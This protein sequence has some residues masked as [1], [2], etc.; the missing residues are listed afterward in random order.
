MEAAI[1]DAFPG[2]IVRRVEIDDDP[3]LMG[4]FGRDVPVLALDDE[5]VCKHFLDTAR[6]HAALRAPSTGSRPV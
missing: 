6:L 5:V 2:A 3:E 1:H 4:R